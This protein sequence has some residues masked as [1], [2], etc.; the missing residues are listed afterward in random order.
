MIRTYQFFCDHCGYKR[1]TNGDD[2]QDLTQVKKA[3]I[4][5]GTPIIDPETKKVK[6]P[7]SIT[8]IKTF[9]CP[10]CG[11]CIKAIKIKPLE[12]DNESIN[13]TDGC[14][15]GTERQEI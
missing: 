12:N 14:K 6:V 5:R 1:I 15:E 7:K 11:F 2:L 3:P 13:R 10:N 9:K 4:P 8:R